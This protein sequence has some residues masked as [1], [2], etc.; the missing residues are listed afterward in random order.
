MN[1][2]KH[3]DER[4]VQMFGKP[5]SEDVTPVSWLFMI[6]IRKNMQQEMAKSITTRPPELPGHYWGF[7]FEGR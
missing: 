3:T 1:I 7:Y 4:S 5:V 2:L 6:S